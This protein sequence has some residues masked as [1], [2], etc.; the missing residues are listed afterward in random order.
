MDKRKD[1]GGHSTAGKAGRPKKLDEE[2]ANTRI[3]RGLKSL[4]NQEEEEDNVNEFLVGFIPTE[5]G[6]MFIA[7]HLLGKPK[8]V[9]ETTII[10]TDE[11][12]IGV[13]FKGN[14]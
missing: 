7:Q 12:K 6:Q 5:R 11:K 3:M 14:K 2:L 8:E 1:N 10:N 4:Y 9:S 13:L